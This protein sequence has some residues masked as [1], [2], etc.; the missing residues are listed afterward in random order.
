VPRQDVRVIVVLV[1]PDCLAR[2]GHAA[3][4]P[5]A[6]GQPPVHLAQARGHSALAPELERL[7]I[8]G[9]EMEARDLVTGDARE[10]V[11]RGPQDFLDV[12]R[13]AHGLRDGVEDLEVRLDV[14]PA[15]CPTPPV[16]AGRG[17]TGAP[18]Q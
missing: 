7:A 10:R 1:D 18:L 6:D 13:A 11:D 5:F 14:W 16:S 3:D 2:D 9:E 12:E 4:E 17:A 8:L 15:G